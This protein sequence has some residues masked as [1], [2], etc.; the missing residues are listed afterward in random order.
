MMRTV[1]RSSI[2]RNLHSHTPASARPALNRERSVQCYRA[3]THAAEANVN[4]L[5]GRL[6][7]HQRRWAE[8]F[9]AVLD[10]DAQTA[11]LFAQANGCIESAGVSPDL[12]QRLL[13]DAEERDLDAER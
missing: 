2:E 1:L 9:S 5:L 7:S 4:R 13:Q 6:R 10:L 3:L 11:I 8:A 12:G